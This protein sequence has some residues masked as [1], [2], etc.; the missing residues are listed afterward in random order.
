[1][2]KKKVV[3]VGRWA[4]RGKEQLVLVRPYEDGLILHQLFYANEVRAFEDIEGPAKLSF[5]EKER[6]LA[7][8]LIDQ[9]T[10][11]GVRGGEVPRHVQRQGARAGRAEGRGAGDHDRARSAASAD[12]RSFRRAEEDARRRTEAAAERAQGAEEDGTEIGRRRRRAVAEEETRQGLILPFVSENAPLSR[13]DFDK[14]RRS[15][16]WPVLD[17]TGL[18]PGDPE[19]FMR[20]RPATLVV[21]EFGASWPRWMNPA[22]TGDLA[23]VAQHYEGSPNDLVG[24]VANRVMRL[25]QA[26]LGS[27]RGRARRERSLATKTRS[28]ARSV[29]A[30]G[31]M[32]HLRA[33]GGVP[34]DA[35]RERGARPARRTRSP[36]SP[37]RSS[38]WRARRTSS[39]RCASARKRRSTAARYRRFRCLCQ[40]PVD[41]R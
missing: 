35:Q 4:A 33:A 8:K 5:T 13:A 37:P 3:A 24:Q 25:T 36:D 11:R 16:F 10:E 31:L 39:S 40:Q 14:S 34:P 41:A 1:M 21:I 19:D 6:D 20:N 15:L 17:A 2:K 38:R 28:A 23:V 9:L 22:H 18:R 12:H 32:A 29:L 26:G 7:V 27:R 30:R